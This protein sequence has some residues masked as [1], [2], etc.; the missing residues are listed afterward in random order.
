MQRALSL[1]EREAEAGRG[2]C[3]GPRGGGRAAPEVPGTGR[4]LMALEDG[5]SLWLRNTDLQL[6]KQDCWSLTQLISA[7]GKGSQFD[8]LLGQKC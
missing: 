8:R 7:T 2:C 6:K 5:R 1:G 3:A 4:Q